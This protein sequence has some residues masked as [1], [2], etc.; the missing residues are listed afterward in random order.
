M[1]ELLITLLIV[2]LVFGVL[3][4]CIQLIPLPHPFALIAQLIL[5]VIL[6]LVLL[7]YLL[8]MLHMPPM[9]R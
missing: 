6:I 7:S 9:V 2:L 8:P 4:Y 1:I 3:F 5:G